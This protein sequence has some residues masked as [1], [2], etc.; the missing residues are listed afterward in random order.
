MS[1]F[2]IWNPYVIPNYPRT[3]EFVL[4]NGDVDGIA[5]D[6]EFIES[7]LKDIGIKVG[8]ANWSIEPYRSNYFSEYLDEEDW[9]DIWQVIWKVKVETIEEIGSLPKKKIPWIETNATGHDWL[10][11]PADNAIIGCLV[12][13]DFNSET[14]LK[15]AQEA[16]TVDRL[17]KQMQKKY[18]VGIPTFS[19]SEVIGKYKQLQVDLGKFPG[20]FFA[21]G[22]DYAERVIELCKK[23]KG[24]VHYA[25]RLEE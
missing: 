4:T 16:I 22:P 17:L 8:I 12:I 13:A 19:G 1:A 15:K 6:K 25:A 7:L 10:K 5:Q 21:S 24:T 14:A 9:R 3:L 23:A 11:R 20:K 2:Y 18:S